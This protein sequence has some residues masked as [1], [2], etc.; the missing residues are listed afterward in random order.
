MIYVSGQ[1]TGNPSPA[2]YAFRV[3]QGHLILRERQQTLTSGNALSATLIGVRDALQGL[4][5]GDPYTI[6]MTNHALSVDLLNKSSVARSPAIH[7]LVTEIQVLTAQHGL[8]PEYVHLLPETDPDLDEIIRLSEDSARLA[9]RTANSPAC[10]RCGDMMTIH[11]S[12]GG[13][14]WKCSTDTCSG[15]LRLYSSP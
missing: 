9:W 1:A 14:L 11:H 5:Q 13:K 8:N 15:T 3:K 7:A 10:P 2:G 4:T 12:R 6:V